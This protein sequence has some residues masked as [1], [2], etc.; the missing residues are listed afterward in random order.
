M[1]V[2]L[3]ERSHRLWAALPLAGQIALHRSPANAHRRGWLAR[4]GP[5]LITGASDDDPAA[6]PPIRKPARNSAISMCWTML[7]SYPLMAAIQEISARIGR[8]TGQGIAGNI[9]AHY[10]RLASARR[11]LLLV[12]ANIINL[13]ADLGAMGDALRLMIGGHGTCSTSC[14]FAVLFARC[15]RFSRDTSA[16]SRS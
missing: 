5:G 10:P 13:G 16:M 14:C 8:V 9:R 2:H 6:S 15:W 1:N 7:F 3:L 4:L 11:R 12:V